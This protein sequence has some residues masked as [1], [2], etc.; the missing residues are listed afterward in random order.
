MQFK[1]TNQKIIQVFSNKNIENQ[2]LKH[3]YFYLL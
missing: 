3:D 2:Y 1:G